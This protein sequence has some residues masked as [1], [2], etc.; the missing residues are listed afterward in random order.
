VRRTSTSRFRLDL[1][2]AVLDAAT[3]YPWVY[4]PSPADAYRRGKYCFYPN[5][6]G[7]DAFAFIRDGVPQLR[8]E[9]GRLSFEAQIMDWADEVTYAIHDLEDWYRAGWVPLG[10]RLGVDSERER[11]L[12]TILEMWR[13]ERRDPHGNPEAQLAKRIDGEALRTGEVSRAFNGLFGG[14]EPLLGRVDRDFDGSTAALEEVHFM[15]RQLFS[16]FVD[17]VEQWVAHPDAPRRR[18]HNDLAI[19]R[20]VRLQNELIRAILRVYVTSSPRL[21][22]QQHGQRRIVAE[23]WELHVHPVRRWLDS[24]KASGLSLFPKHREE[25]MR[26][27]NRDPDL[28]HDE[29]KAELL[30]LVADYLSGLSDA[31]AVTLHGRLLGYQPGAINVFLA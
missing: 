26:D 2:R 16:S 21:I 8:A 18:H 1:T 3:K 10:L 13:A 15:R 31:A 27:V 28:E 12:H 5:D 7:R 9:D 14:D 24:G 4:E 25:R 17:D 30:R 6:A 20:A 19:P 22:T 29:R 11:C 23:L